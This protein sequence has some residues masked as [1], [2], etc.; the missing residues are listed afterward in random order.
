MAIAINGRPKIS[1]PDIWARKQDRRNEEN[2]ESCYNR[3]FHGL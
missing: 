3:S 1:H 2:H